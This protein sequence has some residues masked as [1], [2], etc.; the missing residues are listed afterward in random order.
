MKKTVVYLLLCI[1][2]TL[3]ACDRPVE[4]EGTLSKE[5]ADTAD[6]SRVQDK[7]GV[8]TDYSGLTPYNADWEV[9]SYYFDEPLSELIPD[10]GYGTVLPYV[11]DVL[12]D[13]D[14]EVMQN[15]YGLCTAEGEI[16]TKPVYSEVNEL[17]YYPDD[18]DYTNYVSSG[19]ILIS[20]YFEGGNSKYAVAAADGSWITDYIYNYVYCMDS[21]AVA[22]YTEGDTDC[23]VTIDSNGKEVYPVAGG[24]LIADI[25]EGFARVQRGEDQQ[26]YFI[27]ISGDRVLGPYEDAMNFSEGVASVKDESGWHYI[28]DSGNIVLDISSKYSY[29]WPFTNGY[30][31]LIVEEGGGVIIDKGGNVLVD[32]GLNYVGNG[33]W[34]DYTTYPTCYYDSNADFTLITY[35]GS[36][37]IRYTGLDR[38]FYKQEDGGVTLFIA[39][40]DDGVFIEIEGEVS[41]DNWLN[42]DVLNISSYTSD[43]GYYGFID[44]KGNFLIKPSEDYGSYVKT[45]NDGT[46]ILLIGTD[47]IKLDGTVILKNCVSATSFVGTDYIQVQD[48]YSSGYITTD[49]EWILRVSMLNSMPD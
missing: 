2:L 43:T 31:S 19:M 33:I 10:D 28:D 5:T 48:K 9:K 23:Y 32:K 24:D 13:A 45:E 47:L 12:Y 15:R 11:G 27:N 1:V 20:K 36:E 16:I 44:L 17:I 40:G 21:F 14:G 18:Y 41:I 3:S 25:S 4:H 22:Y 37:E 8:D 7:F 42:E 6:M 38:Y 34:G 26:Y 49:G 46:K 39:G 29:C 30:A 35:K